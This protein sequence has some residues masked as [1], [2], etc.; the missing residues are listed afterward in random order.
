MGECGRR[1]PCGAAPLW[2][3]FCC[4]AR[5]ELLGES[6]PF[7]E[8]RGDARG[9][10]PLR[11]EGVLRCGDRERKEG[12]ELGETERK[13]AEEALRDRGLDGVRAREVPPLDKGVA[14]AAGDLAR[15]PM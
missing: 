15:C 11:G 3:L 6:A 9:E 10:D 12:R 4:E 1:F 2:E 13:P 7:G 8:L 14:G 5:S